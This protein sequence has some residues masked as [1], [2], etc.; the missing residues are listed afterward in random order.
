MQTGREADNHTGRQ[1]GGQR[2]QE[3]GRK[4]DR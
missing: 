1:E 2:Y 3:A 4:T